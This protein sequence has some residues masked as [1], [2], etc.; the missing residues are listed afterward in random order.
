MDRL[1][2]TDDRGRKTAEEGGGDSVIESREN[3]RVETDE[4]E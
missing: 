2:G 4:G 3:L 1:D